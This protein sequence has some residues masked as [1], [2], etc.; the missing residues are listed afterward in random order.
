[1][2]KSLFE[3]TLKGWVADKATAQTENCVK[4]V[5][6]D[7]REQLD[8]W[9]KANRL[10]SFVDGVQNLSRGER[11][12]FKDGVDVILQD[13]S[14]VWN[15]STKSDAPVTRWMSDSIA[16]LGFTQERPLGQR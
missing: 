7:S 1:V 16:A 15:P 13:D 2:Q 8:S 11:L 6:A 14:E 12:G 5:K 9:L 3:V 10:T 4:W